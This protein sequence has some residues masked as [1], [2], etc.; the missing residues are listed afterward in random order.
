MFS[1]GMFCAPTGLSSETKANLALL[2]ELALVLLLAIA[3]PQQPLYSSNQNTYFL[4][5]FARA[6]VGFLSSDWLAQTTDPFPVFSVLISFSLHILGEQIFYFYQI[7][8]HA[9]YLYSLIGIPSL[10]L[11]ITRWS[12][13]WI[14]SVAILFVVNSGILLELI[15][16]HPAAESLKPIFGYNNILVRGVAGQYVLGPFF[17]PSTFGVFILLSILMFV[18]G[19]I[20]LSFVLLAVAANVHT[21]YLLST[22]MFACTYAALL[23]AQDKAVRRALALAALCLL[24]LLPALAYNYANFRPTSAEVSAQAQSILVDYRIPHHALVSHWFSP[25]VL[26]QLC[27]VLL[28]AYLARRT[29]LLPILLVPLIVVLFLTAIQVLTSS[30]GLALL[31][32]WRTSVILV[33]IASSVVL[34]KATSVLIDQIKQRLVG[35]SFT[36][37]SICLSRLVVLSTFVLIAYSGI[38]NLAK[39]LAAPRVGVS[40]VTKFVHSTY[41]PGDLFL[42]PPELEWFRLASGVPI[43]ADFKSHPYKD[44]EVVEWFARLKVAQAFYSAT[45]EEACNMLRNISARYGVTHVV[46]RSPVSGCG[47]LE[48]LYKDTNFV[49]YR[50]LHIAAAGR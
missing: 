29:R 12:L 33:P 40:A 15:K 21:S 42:V 30:K 38:T 49:V 24:L 41:R 4:H 35:K 11:G 17:Q 3:L 10:V 20:T 6:G 19:R 48:E 13:K 27:V 46:A 16:W 2:G 31:F 45:A 7:A 1:K 39:T 5:G 14:S 26:V 37:L 44:V 9:V 36:S 50:V 25:L 8:I 28:A 34:F 18:K 32:P 22:A 23:L 43:L 47:L